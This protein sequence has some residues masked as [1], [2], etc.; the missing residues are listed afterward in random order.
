MEDNTGK[1]WTQNIGSYIPWTELY[2]MFRNAFA[3]IGKFSF[4]PDRKWQLDCHRRARK[5]NSAQSAPLHFLFKHTLVDRSNTKSALRASASPMNEQ[6][7][8][9]A[10]AF[11]GLIEISNGIYP[12]YF[13]ILI[14]TLAR[15]T[16]KPECTRR[17]TL[18]SCN[19]ENWTLPICAL[20]CTML[21]AI[22]PVLAQSS[23]TI[24]KF[25]D[26]SIGQLYLCKNSWTPD[27]GT[28]RHDK[29]LGPA[30]GSIVIPQNA[31]LK[32]KCNFSF[33]E[34]LSLLKTLPAER[35]VALD[36]SKL[37][38]S[39]SQIKGLSHLE[40]IQRLNL[41]N[42]EVDD[43]AFSEIATL[44][45]LEC[46]LF[47]STQLKGT[48]FSKLM[49]LPKLRSLTIGHNQLSNANF[50]DLK[51]LTKLRTLQIS[52]A[53]INDQSL[54]DIATI[55]QL[56]ALDIS[57]NK[58]ISDNGIMQLAKLKKLKRLELRGLK[59]SSKSILALSQCHLKHLECQQEN[60]TAD[61]TQAIQKT[62]PGIQIKDLAK[63]RL[64][65]DLFAP[66]H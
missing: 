23:S 61:E 7:K 65:E 30:Q 2:P 31:R 54:K 33:A 47:Q 3:G 66:L 43:N 32:L 45:N 57:N 20:A 46:L 6:E 15:V 55:D 62:F 53:Q 60:Y 56:E 34:N 24:I 27:H 42:T 1:R 35:F 50:K 12:E 40:K 41:E 21:I 29:P 64:P 49:N 37:P 59:I 52:D 25:P 5:W 10:A 16:L 26:K 28:R 51:H 17:Y 44:K 63:T 19:R 18:N 36:L 14:I 11:D 4:R 9:P 39:S 13:S 48:G 58:K 8:L 38:L 22:R